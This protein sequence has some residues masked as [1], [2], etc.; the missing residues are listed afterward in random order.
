MEKIGAL[1]FV[2]KGGDR[3]GGRQG[4]NLRGKNGIDTGKGEK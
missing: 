2:V 3:T 4:K 1:K